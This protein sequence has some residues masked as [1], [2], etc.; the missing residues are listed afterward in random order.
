M[1]GKFFNE[2]SWRLRQ[3]SDILGVRKYFNTKLYNLILT[4]A[5]QMH[6]DLDFWKFMNYG[7][8]PTN[9]ADRPELLPEDEDDRVCIQLYQH[10]VETQDMAGKSVLEV[11]CGRGGG[12]SYAMR[13]LKPKHY[14]GLDLSPNNIAFCR[15]RYD[16]EGL[17]FIEG[18]A[19]DL[20]FGENEFDIVVNIEAS[21][22]YDSVPIFFEQVHR[23]LKPG[24]HLFFADLR[25]NTKK[26][27]ALR[28][29]LD[30]T[31]FERVTCDDVTQNVL[32]ALTLDSERKAE[33]VKDVIPPFFLGS[34]HNFAAM[35]GS[36]MYKEFEKGNNIYLS[37]I[38]TKAS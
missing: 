19:D 28:D 14:V 8:D 6:I 25:H 30:S 24:G 15:E 1:S 31:P 37:C 7:Y 13:Y 2:L 18:D 29:Q 4:R 5:E 34:F 35:K 20:P 38:L 17:E 32:E 33:L 26:L 21:N 12:A 11:S 10:L 22:G 3:V 9:P 36:Y 27:Q 23:V 16:H